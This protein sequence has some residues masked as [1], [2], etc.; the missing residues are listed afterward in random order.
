M[1]RLAFPEDDYLLLLGRV[2]YGVSM[3]EWKLLGDL[4]RLRGLPPEISVEELAWRTTGGI[5]DEVVR[6][7]AKVE[8]VDVRAYLEVCV[9]QLR[10]LRPMR[11]DILH[12]RPATI[13]GAQR[14]YRW[15]RRSGSVRA[16]AIDEA[17]LESILQRVDQ[18]V[19][20]INAVRL[21]AGSTAARHRHST[22]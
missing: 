8:D 14:L 10:I 19:T 7:L 11:N 17:R 6:H 16:F 12:A 13:N 9:A 22:P 18:A 4:S 3:V 5:A 15:V 2:S 21:P 20:A 1:S